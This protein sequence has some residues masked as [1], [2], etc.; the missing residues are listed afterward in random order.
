MT[1]ALIILGCLV[2]VGFPLWLLDRRHSSGDAPD[3][4]DD[5]PAQENDGE[6]CC[7]LHLQCEKNSLLAAP[8]EKPEY[9]EDEELDAFRGRQ[10]PDCA[11]EE[12]E[13]FSE[14]LLTLLPSDVAPWARSLQQRGI[15]LPESVR[16]E[17]LMIVAEQRLNLSSH[18]S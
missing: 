11:P 6:E 18:A 8:T 16:E 9:F 10:A 13:Q 1:A 3:P 17:L 2:A 14:V 4:V 5:A 15:E 7:G 12:A